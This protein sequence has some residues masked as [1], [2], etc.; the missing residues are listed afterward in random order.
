MDIHNSFSHVGIVCSDYE[1]A[2]DFYVNCLG[3]K[4]YRISFSFNRNAKKIELLFNS[5]YI[6]ELFIPEEVKIKTQSCE[7]T[8][9]DHIAFYVNDIEK[10]FENVKQKGCD[11]IEPKIDIVTGKKYMFIIDPDGFKIEFYEA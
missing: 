2:I 4:I 7:C 11:F 8:G 9:C 5:K 6:I 1:K 3:M 10:I